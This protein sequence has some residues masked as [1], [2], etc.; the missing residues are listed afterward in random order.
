MPN[1]LTGFFFLLHGLV[2]VLY[3]GQSARWFELQPGM[4]WPDGSWVF[5]TLLGNASTRSLANL[6][7][8]LASAGFIAAGI[9][10]ILNQAW[11]YPVVIG[12]SLLSALLIL[13]FWDGKREK[14]ADKGAVGLLI[15]LTILTVLIL[16][17]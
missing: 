8:A 12:S 16:S 10:L 5:G 15:N 3:L 13:V 6:S 4:L 11:W 17:R 2:H 9:G 14:L 7:C 1:F